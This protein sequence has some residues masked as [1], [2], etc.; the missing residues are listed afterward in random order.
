VGD[1]GRAL[2]VAGPAAERANNLLPH[3]VGCA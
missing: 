3:T 2:V 1:H